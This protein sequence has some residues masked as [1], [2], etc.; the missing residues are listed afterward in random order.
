MTQKTTVSLGVLQ[1]LTDKVNV[2]YGGHS[3]EVTFK[4]AF[5]TCENEAAYFDGEGRYSQKNIALFCS[6]VTGW[7]VTD[8]SGATLPITPEIVSQLDTYLIDAIVTAMIKAVNPNTK[9]SQD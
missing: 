8:D 5:W 3:I 6:A 7:N 4:K 2:E 1:A 9:S